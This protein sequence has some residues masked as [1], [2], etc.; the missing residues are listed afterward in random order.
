[1][2]CILKYALKRCIE[3]NVIEPEV[4]KR[5]LKLYYDITLSEEALK[6][7]IA[8]EQKNKNQA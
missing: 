6:S 7:R 3:N 2:I 4:I 5:Y 1:M 8:Q